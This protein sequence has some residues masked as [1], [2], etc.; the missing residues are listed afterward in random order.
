MRKVSICLLIK[1]EN[2]YIKEWISHHIN[3]GI[4]HFYI[5]DNGSAVPISKT[6]LESF[7]DGLFT[8]ID[9]SGLHDSMQ[10]EAYNHC[11]KNFGHES[12]WIAFIDTDEFIHWSSEDVLDKYSQFDSIRIEWVLYN[13]NGL[14]KYD[15][16][17]VQERFTRS[18]K[19]NKLG[20]QYKSI[21]HPSKVNRMDVHDAD[22]CN[23]TTADDIVLNH[24]YTRSLEEWEEKIIRGSCGPFC[25]RRYDEFFEYNPDLIEY[26]DENFMLKH[27]QYQKPF[28]SFDVRIMAHPSRRD[29]VLTTLNQLGMDE[30]IVSYDDRENGGDSLY[31]AEKAWKQPIERGITHRLVLQDDVILCNDFLKVISKIIND[32]P[33]ACISLYNGIPLDL[34]SDKGNPYIKVQEVCGCGI[35]LPSKY[36]EDCWNWINSQ[37][38]E[39]HCPCDDEMIRRYCASH[40]IKI[41]STIPL[42]IQHIGDTEYKSLL[43]VEYSHVRLSPLYKDD[44][45]GILRYDKQSVMNTS[46]KSCDSFRSSVI[47]KRIE[48]ILKRR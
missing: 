7:D 9:W 22:T 36:I 40:S 45:S 29:N 2:K 35:I 20:Y 17:P 10:I 15:D 41:Y 37:P 1:D 48:K 43:S 18:L 5:Y 13:A 27:Q 25:L 32:I 4:D 21:V 47:R 11:I 19:Y 39:N 6:V 14:L 8:F 3:I 26:K 31:T 44:C 34:R 38:E 28:Q 23:V 42:T 33:D 12:E 30:S 16:R 24:Y 46:N